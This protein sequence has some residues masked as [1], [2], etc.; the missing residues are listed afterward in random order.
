MRD[1]RQTRFHPNDRG[2]DVFAAKHEH[3]YCTD[4]APPEIQGQLP[5]AADEVKIVERLI[6]Q[7][8]SRDM[9]ESEKTTFRQ[10]LQQL[11][12]D[13]RAGRRRLEDAE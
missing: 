6:D 9:D 3:H 7:L 8:E 12:E 5:S 10:E 2:P 1:L 11:A 13:I 4:H